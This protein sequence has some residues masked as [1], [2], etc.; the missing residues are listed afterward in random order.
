M[1]KDDYK[2]I[3]TFSEELEV[4]KT[5]E[6]LGF[7]IKQRTP[8]C[9]DCNE[10][11]VVT[12]NGRLLIENQ[13][14]TSEQAL[15]ISERIGNSVGIDGIYPYIDKKGIIIRFSFSSVINEEYPYKHFD[16]YKQYEYGAI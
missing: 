5:L 1:K 2:Y 8:C 15:Y 12:F 7:E 13:Q 4:I 16:L 11:F 3:C 6:S 14:I 10:P 9:C